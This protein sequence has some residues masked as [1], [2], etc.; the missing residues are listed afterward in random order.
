ME[1]TYSCSV[2]DTLT[3]DHCYTTPP[4]AK[5]RCLPLWLKVSEDIPHAP[6]TVQ[7]R[8]EDGLFNYACAVLNDGLILLEL[9]DAIHEGDVERIFRCWKFM[10][11]YFRHGN[12]YKY[13]LEAFYF[14]ANIVAIV[15]PR[16]QHQLLWSRV[17]NTRGGAGN[18]IQSDLFME[19]CIKDLKVCLS[20]IG[21]NLTE[22][23]IV[24]ESKSLDGV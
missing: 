6:T 16:L 15:S 10:L 5:K 3:H 19:H 17:I 7:E 9:R 2:P 18:S 8:A 12:R 24:N 11:L 23:T 20:S 22:E 21:A 4:P 1:H 13:V 14:I